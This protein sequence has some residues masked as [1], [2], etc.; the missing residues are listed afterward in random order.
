L[1]DQAATANAD[2]KTKID[3]RTAEIRAD[4][5]QRSAKLKQA[6]A[7]AKEALAP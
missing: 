2:A 6:R 4:H 5:D 3:Q 1:Q 7:L